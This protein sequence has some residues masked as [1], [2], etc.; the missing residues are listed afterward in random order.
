MA[1]VA[2]LALAT[3]DAGGGGSNGTPPGTY[4]GVTLNVAV[5]GLSQFIYVN[6]DVQ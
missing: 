6:V 2:L 1:V 5:A 3:A 4:N